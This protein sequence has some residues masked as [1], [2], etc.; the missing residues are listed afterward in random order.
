MTKFKKTQLIAA[1]FAAAASLAV[2]RLSAQQA[3]QA[4]SDRAAPAAKSVV[5]APSDAAARAKIMESDTWKQVGTEY[6]KWLAK[7][8]IYTPSQVKRI[9]EQLDA[10]IQNLPTGELQSFLDDWLAKLKVLNGKDFQEAQNW[11]G[12]YMTN[13]AQGYRRNYLHSMGLTDI[14]SMSAAQLEAAITNIRADRMSIMQ[15]QAAF[16][17]NQRQMVKA[18][19]QETAASQQAQQQYNSNNGAAGF[20]TFQSPYRPPKYDPPPNPQMHWMM[21]S[22]GQLMP[23]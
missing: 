9:N 1:L 11:L 17:S 2:D 15:K 5:A 3:N 21:G 19:Q 18:V 14:P 7:Q 6:Q 20:N 22:D 23:F 16:E 8:P 12:A 10:Q 13:M 4:I